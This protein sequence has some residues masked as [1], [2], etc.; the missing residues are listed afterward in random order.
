MDSSLRSLV[1]VVIWRIMAI[2]VTATVTYV[3]TGKTE[4]AVAIGTLDAIVK[5]AIHFI[6]ERIWDRISFGREKR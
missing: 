4:L 6:H 3:V 2:C 1:K 5:T